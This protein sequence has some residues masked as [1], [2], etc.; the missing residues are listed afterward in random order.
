MQGRSRKRLDEAAL[1][2]AA[3]ED[4]SAC[5]PPEA[6]QISA[7]LHVSCSAGLR[8]RLVDTGKQLMLAPSIPEEQT[9]P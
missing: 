2:Q 9:H 6:V 1:Q 3:K 5:Q 8:M 4:D 7:Q